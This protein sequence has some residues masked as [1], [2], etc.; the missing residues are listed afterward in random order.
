MSDPYWAA[1]RIC[2]AC[3]G[4]SIAGS[5]LCA[6]CRRIM[7][8]VETRKNPQ[9]RGRAVDK[10]APA[11]GD[12]AAVRPVDR[13]LPLLLTDMPLELAAGTR[14]SA[15]WTH[16]TAGDESSVVLACKL[17]NRMQ[18]DLTEREFEALVKALA[19]R[20]EGE[21]FDESAF[22]PDR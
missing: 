6:R 19:R 3:G 21:P 7:A 10:Q 9:G 4:Q 12:E 2:R 18:T 15:E 11:A 20:F 8:R 17:V 14:R 16:L 22:P 13:R 5:Y 1:S